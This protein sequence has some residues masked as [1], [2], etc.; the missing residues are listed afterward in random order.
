MKFWFLA[1]FIPTML[2]A[3]TSTPKDQCSPIDLRNEVLGHVRDQGSISWCYAFAGADMLNYSFNEHEKIS[4]ADV[5]IG[6][7]QTSIGLFMRWLDINLLHK[8]DP[9]IKKEAHQTGF[10][11]KSL[12]NVMK[13]GWCPESV[14]PSEKWTKV[15]RTAEG[16]QE[17]QVLLEPAM[18]DIEKLHQSRKSLTEDNIPYYFKFKNVGVKEFIQM[19]KSTFINSFYFE[20]RKTVC[21]DDRRPFDHKKDVEMVVKNPW[22]FN[23]LGSQLEHGNVVG[24]DYDARVLDNTS[25]HSVAVN[26]LHT[27]VIVGRRWNSGRNTC[28]Y[29]I[30][31]SHGDQ[32]QGEYDPTIECDFGNIWLSEGQIFKNMTSIVY[33]VEPKN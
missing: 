7:N 5:A 1:A 23:K 20:L 17:E 13:V 29:L 26:Q 31:N 2:F 16:W 12:M 19:V 10:N 11:K 21:K 4:A 14:F 33:M 30:R 28:E 22:I 8:S 9:S 24:L 25:N 27:S 18:L 32:C 15:T 3:H 6:Y